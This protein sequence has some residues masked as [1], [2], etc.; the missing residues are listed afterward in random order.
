ML[1][2]LVILYSVYSIIFELFLSVFPCLFLSPE[3][4]KSHSIWPRYVKPCFMSLKL[5]PDDFLGWN[6]L[7]GQW[8][9]LIY[10]PRILGHRPFLTL[11]VL[12]FLFFPPQCYLKACFRKTRVNKEMKKNQGSILEL[13]L[14]EIHTTLSSLRFLF[15]ALYRYVGFAQ[16][17]L[18]LLFF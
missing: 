3:L 17:K 18:V 5:K 4:A 13:Y 8:K 10:N 12:G 15:S 16:F 14:T 1:Y 7:K 2:I 9:L 11:T 6:L